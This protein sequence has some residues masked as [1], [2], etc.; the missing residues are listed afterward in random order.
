MKKLIYT[1]KLALPALRI[2]AKLELEPN[3]VFLHAGTRVGARN[4]GIRIS[5]KLIPIGVFPKPFRKLKAREIEDALC[6][7]KEYFVKRKKF[8]NGNESQ[9]HS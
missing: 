3:Y 1:K 7:Y 8:K 5:Q 2:G 9:C 4:L 6:I